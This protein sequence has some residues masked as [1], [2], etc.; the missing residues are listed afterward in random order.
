MIKLVGGTFYK[1]KATKAKLLRFIAK[2]KTLSFGEESKKF[3]KAFAR[4]QGRKEAIFVNSGSSANLALIQ[5][6]LNLGRLKRGDKVAFSAV[7]WSTNVM[8]LIKLGLIP[9]PMDIE[10]DTLNVSS[11]EV[12]KAI[13]KHRVKAV[14]ITNLLGFSHDLGNT[15]RVCK[16][17]KVILLEDNCESLGSVEKGT[18]LGNF[19]LA[20]TFSF[21][22]GHHMSTIEGGMICTDDAELA[23]ALRMIRAH[24]WDRHLSAATQT[25][26]RTKHAIDSFYGLY[27]F[28]DL[29]YNFRPTDINGFLGN[30]QLPHLRD[31]IARRE[32]TYA[33]FEKAVLKQPQAFRPLARGHMDTLSA[34]A[35]P[36]VC[37]TKEVKD[38]VIAA[39]AGKV[40]IRPIVGGNMILQ[41]FFKKYFPQARKKH[42]APN[43][44]TVHMLG[45]YLPIHPDMTAD[46]KKTILQTLRSI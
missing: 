13:R 33:L 46:E 41:P 8:P 10:L 45:L 4:W 23:D 36:L 7:T 40:E 26:L 25:A 9:V 20:S 12:E 22:V 21:F 6:L 1:E 31:I 11:K 15:R 29:G 18:R 43:A 37:T 42:P 39:C 24:G 19:G 3:E 5:A 35:F 14:F 32:K 2:A 16:K 44:T 27:T 30:T 17:H 34:F 28:Y 38:R